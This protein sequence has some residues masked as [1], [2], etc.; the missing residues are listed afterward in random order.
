MRRGPDDLPGVRGWARRRGQ[1]DR[2]FAA[3]RTGLAA[4]R[5]TTWR[6]RSAVDPVARRTL[7]R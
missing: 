7:E 4:S 6:V 3:L 2:L 1:R 5:S